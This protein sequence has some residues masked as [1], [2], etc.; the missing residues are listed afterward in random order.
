MLGLLTP[1]QQNP[2][3]Y[4]EQAITKFLLNLK[5]PYHLQ[6]ECLHLTTMLL[7]I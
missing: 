2:N 4:P 5:L 3:F 6:L 1:I 7:T